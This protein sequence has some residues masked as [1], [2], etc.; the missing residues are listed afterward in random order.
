MRTDTDLRLFCILRKRADPVESG[1]DLVEG[2][3]SVNI[4]FEFERDARLSFYG[5]DPNLFEAN[6]TFERFLN[7]DTHALFDFGWTGTRIGDTDPNPTGLNLGINFDLD[8]R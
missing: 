6:N 1:F 7:M 5:I 8:I 2:V 4:L 3:L